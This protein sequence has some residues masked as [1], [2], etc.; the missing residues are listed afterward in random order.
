MTA[1]T[2]ALLG[3]YTS[4]I[5]RQQETRDSNERVYTQLMSSREEA[6]LSQRRGDQRGQRRRSHQRPQQDQ[7]QAHCVQRARAAEQRAD[8][9]AREEDHA[10]RLRLVDQRDQ[11]GAETSR[12]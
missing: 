5:V 9:R 6:P 3:Y 4:G 1:L 7:L 8:H 2:V 11:P 10:G 12:N